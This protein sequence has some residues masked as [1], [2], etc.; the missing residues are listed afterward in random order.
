MPAT[1][2]VPLNAEFATPVVFSVLVILMISTS[3][4]IVRLWGI[5]VIIFAVLLDQVASAI[6]LGFLSWVE[7]E[8]VCVVGLYKNPTSVSVA[9]I[10]VL[11]SWSTYPSK[12]GRAVSLALEGRT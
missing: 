7:S 5:S 8:S 11:D 9:P 12:G 1:V 6:C 3:E 2:N 10:E 4:P